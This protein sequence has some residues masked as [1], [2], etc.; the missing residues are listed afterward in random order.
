MRLVI[1]AAGA[2]L[3]S[4]CAAAAPDTILLNGRIFTANDAQP[5]AQAL[6]IKGERVIAIGETAAIVALAGPATRRIELAGRAVVPGFND[7]HLVLD[8]ATSAGVRL[9]GAEALAHGVT[10]LQVFSRSPVAGTVGAFRD[11]DLPL[12]VR[13]LRMPQPDAAGANRDGRPFFPPQPAPRIDVRGM[14][15]VLGAADGERLQQA[16]G[17]AYGSEDPIAIASLDAAAMQA[18]VTALETHGTA[19]VWQ[20]KRPR[21]DRPVAIPAEWYARLSRLGAVVVQAPRAG[22]PLRS[23]LSAGI[24]L[25]LGSGGAFEGFDLIRL[26]TMS[27]MGAEAL[28]V[29]QALAAYSHGAA[30]SEFDEKDKGRLMAGALADLAVLSHDPFTATEEDLGRIRSVLTMIGGRPVYDVPRP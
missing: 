16:V 3:L 19:A 10:S 17:W 4:A 26:A 23:F 22:A 2:L 7:A 14:A 11:A 15:F 27:A 18:Y 6:A 1:I 30:V 13:I 20:A 28:T 21:F 29:D 9:L 25:G 5:W 8:S 12:R 24:A